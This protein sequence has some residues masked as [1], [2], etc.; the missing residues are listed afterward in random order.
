MHCL[1]YLQVVLKMFSIIVDLREVG[2]AHMVLM[3][4]IIY[5]PKKFDVLTCILKTKTFMDKRMKVKY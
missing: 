4:C 3:L 1:P 5:N 2:L